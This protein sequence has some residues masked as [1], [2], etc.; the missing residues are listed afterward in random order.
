MHRFAVTAAAV[1]VFVAP[2]FAATPWQ[3][4]GSH[5]SVQFSVRHMMIS[6]VRGTFGKVSGSIQADDQDLTRSTVQAT[7]D[8]VSIDTRDAK[9]DEHLRSP[10]FF[11]VAKYPTISFTS[12]KVEKA[13]DNRFRVTGDLS[14]HGVMREVV[15]QVESAGPPI[16]DLMGKTRAGARATTKVNRKDYGIVWNK[17]LD[18]GGIAVGD[19]VEITIEVEGIKQDATGG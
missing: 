14:L 12:K 6:N 13:G 16:K 8:V 17:A 5:T 1:V 7:I 3:I 10:D 11:D 4:D 15:L 9:R 18:G 2:A 19:E